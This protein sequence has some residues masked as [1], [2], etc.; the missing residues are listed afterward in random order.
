MSHPRSDSL[1]KLL[2]LFTPFLFLTAVG[3]CRPSLP[4]VENVIFNA[5]VTN[6][7]PDI[8]GPKGP[9]PSE[10]AAAV[11]KRLEQETW[12]SDILRRQT[13][14]AE[15]I[16]GLPLTDGNKAT[17][18]ID[19]Q[20]TFASMREAIQGARNTIDL[21]TYTFEDDQTGRELADLLL[22][23]RAAG[24]QVN[25]IY[26]SVGCFDIPATFFQHLRSGGINVLEYNPLNPLKRLGSKWY[27]FERDHRK[28][29]I[30]DGSIAITGGVNIG[31]RYSENLQGAHDQMAKLESWRDTDV[32][33]EGP[34]VAEFQHLF[35]DTWAKQKGPELSGRT[36]LPALK[37]AGNE[38]VRV[39]GSSPGE[40]N[41]ITF[42][43][44][45]GAIGFAENSVHITAAYFVPDQD[46]LKAL[47]GA[48]EKGV[49]VKL[50]L[51]SSSDHSLVLSAGRSYYA[52]LL[53]SGVKLYERRY[54]LLHAKTA[55]IDG[56]W[57]TIGPPIS[58]C[59]VFCG[60]TK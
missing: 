45:A 48:A 59:G 16:G 50:I 24:V 56:V 49:D 1:L 51:P 20:A 36:Y 18:L 26:D 43:M 3:G 6:Q 15:L 42:L 31:N 32:R 47:T 7:F 21:E 52:T 30:V 29:L 12:W 37:K 34:A 8:I 53:K 4:P 46:I 10:E 5:S 57:F 25:L 17:L 11:I 13:A 38:L 23:K 54:K 9:L 33:I 14:L 22:K 2:F 35:L 41:R 19:D 58:I 44:Y 40:Y 55:V 28:I 39:V 60:I 27:L